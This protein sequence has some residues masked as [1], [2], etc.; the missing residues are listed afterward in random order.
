MFL[1]NSKFTIT[2]GFSIVILLLLAV[3]LV[4]ATRLST[5]NAK[6][7]QIIVERSGKIEII[8]SMR[9]IVRAR[10]LSMFEISILQDAFELD[11]EFMHFNKLA[12]DFIKLRLKLEAMEL[13]K[14]EI[15]LLNKAKAMIRISAPLQ[16]EIVDRII[17]EN[18]A[19]VKKL[20]DEDIPLER[21]ILS[22]FDQF[23]VVVRKASNEA[24]RN[25]EAEYRL[26]YQSILLLGFI[27]I[28]LAIIIMRVV[29]NR[30]NKIEHDLFKEKELAEVTL[31]AIG[32]AVITTDDKGHVAYLNPVAEQ[33]TG[34]SNAEAE[35]KPLPEVYKTLVGD[36]RA[37]V[38]HLAYKTPLD[39]QVVALQRHSILVAKNGMEY[40][41]EDKTSPIRN[42]NGELVGNVVVFRDV[43][44]A[45]DIEQQLSW[46]A[47]HDSLTG[48]ANRLDFELQL[49]ELLESAKRDKREHSLLY[50]DLDQFKVVN[51][52]C[53]HTAGD[54]L[55]KQL[56]AVLD[57]IVRK[58]DTLA[59]LGGDEFGVLLNG[60]AMDRAKEI[61]EQIRMI[62]EDF[63]FE[64]QDKTFKIGVSI[65]L[66]CINQDSEGITS[67]LSAADAAC[68][69]AKDLGRNK[70]WVHEPDN[71]EIVQRRTEI[72]W[73]SR[74]QEALASDSFAVYQQDLVVAEHAEHR[75][76]YHELLIRL[77]DAHGF[78]VSPMSFIPAAERYG[79]MQDIDRWMLSHSLE[80]LSKLD[81]NGGGSEIY[82]INISGQSFGNENFF[83]F[84]VDQLEKCDFSPRQICFEITETAA[85]TNWKQALNFVSELKSIGCFFA[86]DDY[87][88][89]MSSF[90]YLKQLPVDFVK[91]DG[92]L[93]R[94]ICDDNIDFAMVETINK[95]AH[96]MGMF[97]IAEYV[98]TQPVYEKLQELGVDYM[99]GF[100]FHLPLPFYSNTEANADTSV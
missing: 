53:G 56:S 29:I 27:A 8:R 88:S 49:K 76:N 84:V 6:H 19:G 59:R 64:W 77:V 63:R 83:K 94:D 69:V 52:A 71:R 91:I 85:I 2:A 25:A 46:Q 72:Q 39:A 57:H 74:I 75:F 4:S 92:S 26:A 17:D 23:L 80:L 31:H 51:D 15:A 81:N 20:M 37:E 67:V 5:I 16:E 7:K 54:E 87:G 11:D 47:T 9:N 43:T 1:G 100:L 58:S 33:L 12:R 41:V 68:Y 18:L 48:L 62:I 82:A 98:E 13:D 24:V 99:Q 21:G 65:G 36:T 61:A 45:R 73:V 60:C 95:I 30:T 86:L 38:R 34:W 66:V 28:V 89:G 40:V 32:D 50:L 42:R 93:I 44:H 79:I 3:I 78:V 55:L 35:G 10:T 22:V 96:D 90:P 97:T 70:I 14:Q